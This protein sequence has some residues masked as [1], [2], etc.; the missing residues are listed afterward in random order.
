MP[1]PTRP[2]ECGMMRRPL[3]RIAATTCQIRSETFG[4]HQRH[5]VAISRHQPPSDAIRC[6]HRHVGT[7]PEQ[8]A[9]A[10]LRMPFEGVPW[11]RHLERLLDLALAVPLGVVRVCLEHQMQ[12]NA[13]RRNQMQQTQSVYA[14]SILKAAIKC[15]QAQST[16]VQSGII[17]CLDHLEGGRG[18]V[19][20]Y[21]SR[22]KRRVPDEGGNQTSSE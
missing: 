2:P 22:P 11:P 18:L 5:Q 17:N 9:V 14:W 1:L 20:R 21:E 3:L 12:S 7:M 16:A 10:K 13:I 8:L 4:G 6:P 19:H 15:K